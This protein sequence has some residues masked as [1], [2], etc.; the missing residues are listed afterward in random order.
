[1]TVLNRHTLRVGDIETDAIDTGSGQPLLFLHAGEGPDAV[2]D[3]YLRRLAANFRVIAPFHP[4]F[5]SRPRPAW[6]RD[7]G[8]LAYFHLELADR[9]GLRDAV[10]VGA[11]FGGWIAAEMAIRSTACFSRLVL[12][13]PFGVKAG[14]RE[15]TDIADFF[16]LTNADW[17]KVAYTNPALAE[18][19]IASQSDKELANLVRGRESMAYYGWKPFMHNPQLQR[20]LLRIRIPTLVLRG[21]DD[22]VVVPA[23]HKL[24]ADAIPGARLQTIADAGHFPHLEQPGAFAD[25]VLAFTQSNAAGSKHAARAA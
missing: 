15:S 17:I 20:W 23:C 24:Y 8:D 11:S 16:T 1:M 2:S 14:D 9:L 13:D 21:E 4:G 10:L 22:R 3:D 12:V 19:D 5:G 6:F 25:A 18:Q 7:V